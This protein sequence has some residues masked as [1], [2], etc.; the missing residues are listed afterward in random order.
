MPTHLNLI[1]SLKAKLPEA[2]KTCTIKE[3]G[4]IDY[5]TALIQMQEYTASRQDWIPD[6]APN[7][8]T[9]NQIWLCEHPPVFTLGKFGKKE[10]ILN[11]G[12]IP[13]V[14]TDRGGQVTYHG[15]GQLMVYI[16]FNL[17]QAKIGPK[18]FVCLLED[19]IINWLKTYQIDAKREPN[20]PGVYVDGAKI[21]AIGLRIKHGCTY[22]GLAINIDMG[23]EPFSRINPCGY[24][25]QRVV[26]LSSFPKSLSF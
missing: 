15:P 5:K 13:I 10:H 9:K 2:L 1:A 7:D 11:P 20:K 26:N 16:L 12:S 23:L 25:G 3:L 19:W 8:T 6:Q 24:E 21:C 18:K 14:E 17:K 4:R 22:H